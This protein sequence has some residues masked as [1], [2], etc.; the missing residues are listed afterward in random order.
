MFIDPHY[1]LCSCCDVTVNQ[2]VGAL[3]FVGFARDIKLKNAVSPN[4]CGM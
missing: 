2:P 4:G 3:L 1:C